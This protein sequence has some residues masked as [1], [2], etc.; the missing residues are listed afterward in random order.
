[1]S[2]L[3][4][5]RESF[6]MPILESYAFSCPVASF[7]VNYGPHEL[8]EDGVTGYKV[9]F[10]AIDDLA[11]AIIRTLDKSDSSTRLRRNCYMKSKGFSR[12]RI[13]EI[14]S[15]LIE[16]AERNRHEGQP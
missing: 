6:G 14:W 16:D 3:T 4:S 2:I 13:S 9:P 12:E 10:G 1:M 5:E 11:A 8:V 7:D 15:G